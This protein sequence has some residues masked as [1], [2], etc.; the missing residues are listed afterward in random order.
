MHT[1]WNQA[2]SSLHRQVNAHQRRML[3]PKN[4]GTGDSSPE[5]RWMSDDVFVA[6]ELQGRPLQF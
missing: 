6:A 4:T 1:Q 3:C 2:D 5:A